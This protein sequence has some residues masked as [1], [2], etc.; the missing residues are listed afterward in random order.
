M[1]IG[2]ERFQLNG[3]VGLFQAIRRCHSSRHEGDV[4]SASSPLIFDSKLA[5][6]H[7]NKHV[8]VYACRRIGE[9]NFIIFLPR[10]YDATI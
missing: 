4:A 8:G 7:I 1:S 6:P 3:D 9:I 2:I 10:L 5:L